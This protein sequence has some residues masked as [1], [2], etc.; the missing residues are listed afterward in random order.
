MV[1]LAI[2]DTLQISLT[3]IALGADKAVCPVVA[4][5][6]GRICGSQT[7]LGHIENPQSKDTEILKS[8]NFKKLSAES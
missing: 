7:K 1:V 2:L 8:G 3:A 4:G 6:L 5:K